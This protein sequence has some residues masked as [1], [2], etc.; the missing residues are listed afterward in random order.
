MP[1]YGQ[2]T[3]LKLNVRLLKCEIAF[4]YFPGTK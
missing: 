3:Q 1:D 2:S 4:P